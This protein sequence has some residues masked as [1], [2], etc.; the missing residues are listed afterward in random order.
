[1]T[2]PYLIFRKMR[3]EVRAEKLNPA[4]ASPRYRGNIRGIA[5]NAEEAF[6]LARK[7]LEP[8]REGFDK[9]IMVRGGA[10][11]EQAF[12]DDMRRI[13]A[14]PDRVRDNW[15]KAGIHLPDADGNIRSPTFTLTE[16]DRK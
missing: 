2:V 11:R 16:K 1:M 12:R 4:L 6:E 8:T 9:P 3:S 10:E 13:G 7:Y 14:D 15:E 5:N